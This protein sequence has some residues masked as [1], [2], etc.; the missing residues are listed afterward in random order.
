MGVFLWLAPEMNYLQA[1]WSNDPNEN[2]LVTNAVEDQREPFII[3]D[4]Q[5]GVIIAW[6]DYQFN[7]SIFGGDIMAQRL[8]NE[9]APVW[10]GNGIA[11]NAAS[12]GKGHFS[13]VMAEDGY[14]GAVIGWA[15]TPGFFY[16][17]DIFA[18]KINAEGER[19]WALNDVT[20][21]DR[22][23]T[24]SFHQIVRDDSCGAIFTWTHLPGTPGSTDIYAQRVDSAGNTKWTNNGVEICM[25]AESQ[26]NPQLTGDGNSGAIIT[27]DDGRKG[28]GKLN[29]YAQR[30]DYEGNVQWSTDGVEVANSLY[31]Q[32]FPVIVSYGAGGAIIAW[33]ENRSDNM[34]LDNMNIYAQR[35]NSSGEYQW[36]EHGIPVCSA[37][38]NQQV[39]A[40]VSDGE[41]GAI[42]T[43]QDER[44][45]NHDIYAQRIN[46]SGEMQW[47]TN[48]VAATIAP[49]DQ[50]APVAISDNAGGI[51][52][53]W[54]DYRSDPLGDI[55]AQRIN[56]QGT[57]LWNENGTVVCT[58]SG[59]QELPALA[60]DG[61]EGAI[62]VWSD[63]RNGTDYDIYAQLID[64]AGNIGILVDDDLDGIG[65]TEE[66]G[67]DGDNPDYDGNSDGFPDYQQANVASFSTFDQVQYVT[68][69]VPEPAILKNV[70]ATGNPDPYAQG[71]PEVGTYPYYFFSFTITGLAAGG[72]TVATLFLHEGPE[73]KS[74]YKYGPTPTDEIKWY[75]FDYDGE[76]GAVINEDT[77]HLYLVDGLRGDFDITA[78]GT[79]IEPGGP[80][81]VSSNAIT[82]VDETAL[83][84]EQNYPNPFTGQTKIS[85]QLKSPA[86]VVISVIN[87]LG[88]E[89]KILV[90]Q[91]MPPGKHEVV[92]DGK[93]DSGTFLNSGI[94][95]Y[96]MEVTT[97]SG[98][99]AKMKRM[100]LMQ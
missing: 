76:T 41:G 70:Q 28:V 51:I 17:Y 98:N 57:R 32:E 55:Y 26:S 3:T 56:A 80:I 39:P 10:T 18:Q 46:G 25:A 35:L 7:N 2:T 15:R 85:Y 42:I 29:I 78:N 19:K 49:D 4:G 69:A 44:N 14:G 63:K 45:G 64:K 30:I 24:E 36:T 22:S 84:L 92:W 21:S 81:N 53:A 38:G 1:Q 67:P 75:D 6:R 82:E 47:A 23:G 91:P 66:Q 86:R 95:F 37:P 72:N 61:D 48:G 16:N 43:W 12:L 20:V 71:A 40:I 59:Y 77:I 94:Y 50:S 54:W 13:P 5:G 83:I 60:S 96:R 79:I 100:I 27:W 62:I 87:L 9:G 58:A 88:K 68:L 65:N 33:K 99:I 93:D 74:Y 73:V 89:V 31:N 90:N 97:E 8:N 11:I 52:I 34:D